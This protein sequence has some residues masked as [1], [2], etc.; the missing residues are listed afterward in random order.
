MTPA[1]FRLGPNGVKA[2]TYIAEQ[3]PRTLAGDRRRAPTTAEVGTATGL[4]GGRAHDWCH[5]LH[6]GGLIEFGPGGLGWVITDDG[7]R[8]L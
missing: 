2:L 7:K 3:T 4:L 1:Q 5:R 8:A 6:V